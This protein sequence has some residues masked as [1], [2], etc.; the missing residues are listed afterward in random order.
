MSRRFLLSRR[1]AWSHTGPIV[2]SMHVCHWAPTSVPGLRPR[3]TTLGTREPTG[4]PP[5]PLPRS[6]AI[7]VRVHNHSFSLHEKIKKYAHTHAALLP[8]LPR[9]HAWSQITEKQMSVKRR[10]KG[11]LKINA[12]AARLL[13]VVIGYTVKRDRST[14]ATAAGGGRTPSL[15]S[16]S[17]F[18]G[19]RGRPEGVNGS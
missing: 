13:T 6:S 14:S 9:S 5:P 1:R 7:G 12:G 2:A 3:Y 15:V 11:I 17:L 18:E 10:R 19:P 8:P 4:P 16:L